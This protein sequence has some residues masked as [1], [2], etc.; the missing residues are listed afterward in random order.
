MKLGGSLVRDVPAAVVSP[1]S[2]EMQ[3]L[4]RNVADAK[5]FLLAS[6]P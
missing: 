5:Q 6:L 4:D 1:L 3:K 2:D